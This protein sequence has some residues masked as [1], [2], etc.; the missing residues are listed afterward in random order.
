MT[1]L[2]WFIAGKR[3]YLTQL[4]VFQEFEGSFSTDSVLMAPIENTTISFLKNFK[5]SSIN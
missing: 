3:Y 2:A 5:L 4:I 1:S